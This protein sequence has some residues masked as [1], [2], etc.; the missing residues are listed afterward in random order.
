VANRRNGDVNAPK[1]WGSKMTERRFQISN[2][3][4]SHVGCVRRLNEDRYFADP[5]TG[6]WVVADGMGGHDAGDLASEAIVQSLQG[7]PAIGSPGVLADIFE[8]RISNANEQIRQLSAARGNNVI[9]STLVG[10][11][12]F[13]EA[14][15]CV[16]S[17]DSRAYLLRGDT[18]TQLSRDHTEVQELLDRGLLSQAEADNYPRKNVIT[19]AIGVSD[20]IHLD[21]VDGVVQTGDTFL[22]CSDGLTTHVS[23]QEIGEVM[24]GRRAREICEQLVELALDRGGTDNVTVN[25]IQF[26]AAR[27]TIPIERLEDRNRAMDSQ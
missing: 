17:G 7:M 5:Q 13:G 27:A 11:L 4:L 14:F 20:L 8:E 18:L 24:A 21:F 9:G 1:M 25:S 12:F 2:Y 19:H 22:L 3:S 6:V 16:W 10:L 15:R 26:Y 23:S